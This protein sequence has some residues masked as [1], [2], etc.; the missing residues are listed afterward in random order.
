MARP[1]TLFMKDYEMVIDNIPTTGE[2]ISVKG[3]IA[4]IIPND[5]TFNKKRLRK[6]ISY[7]KK[8]KCIVSHPT[9]EDARVV[10]YYLVIK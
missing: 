3:L 8:T 9:F 10:K 6:I 2:G 4:L 7:L 1:K 5:P